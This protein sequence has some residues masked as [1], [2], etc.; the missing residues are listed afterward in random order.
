MFSLDYERYQVHSLL[1]PSGCCNGLSRI[2]RLIQQKFVLSGSWGPEV[3]TLQPQGRDPP[4]APGRT[5]LPPPASGAAC[6][7]WPVA[8]SL[9]SLPLSPRGLLFPV[10]VFPSHCGKKIT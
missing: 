10:C 3:W 9:W 8:A 2:R 6:A 7:P 4:Q 5:F 1:N